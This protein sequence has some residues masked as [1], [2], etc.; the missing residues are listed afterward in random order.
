M[1]A[2]KKN[3]VTRMQ[4]T[5]R[6]AIG[7]ASAQFGWVSGTAPGLRSRQSSPVRLT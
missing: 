1:A 2:V 3:E 5:N 4:G 6:T 7:L